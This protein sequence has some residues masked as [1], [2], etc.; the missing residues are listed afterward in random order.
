MTSGSVAARQSAVAVVFGLAVAGTV[1]AGSYR[2]ASRLAADKSVGIEAYTHPYD[3]VHRTLPIMMARGDGQAYATVA[4]DPELRRPQAW[5]SGS[6]QEALWAHRPLLPYLSAL[7]GVGG[8]SGVEWVQLV[9]VLLSGGLVAAG[10]SALCLSWRLPGLIG[11]A[12]ALLPG[13]LD[14][15]WYLTV[16]PLAVGLVLI[17]YWCW[18]EQRRLAA[19]VLFSLA[20]L[21][22]ETML[23]VPAVVALEELLRRR[24]GRALLVGGVPGLVWL[25]SSVAV[26]LRLGL[27]PLASGS[28]GDLVAPFTGL[29]HGAARWHHWFEP[30]VLASLILAIALVVVLRPRDAVNWAVM[31]YGAV[32][33]L[34]GTNIWAYWGNVARVLLPLHILALLALGRAVGE[35][36]S[37]T[38]VPTP[39]AAGRAT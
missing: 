17:G 22:R 37:G 30:A 4:Q 3:G 35:R 23:V 8:R 32:A 18:W 28:S 15:F 5:F 38:L 14:S 31:A 12:A 26:N 13:A 19:V 34:L 36:E 20:A 39:F 21:G 1:I 25:A 16:D 7:G 29:V 2:Q 33:L 24:P 27:R 9:I 11:A 6:H 10:A